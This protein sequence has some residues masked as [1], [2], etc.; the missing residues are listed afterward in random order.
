MNPLPPS[1]DRFGDELEIA[2]RRDLGTRR[3][4]RY[5]LRGVVSWRPRRRS[6]WECS[7]RSR[8]AARRW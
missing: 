3:R 8:P 7:A 4:R 2:V 5:A 6:R 1:L